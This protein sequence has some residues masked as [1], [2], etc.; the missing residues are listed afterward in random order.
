MFDVTNNRVDRWS[1]WVMFDGRCG[2]QPFHVDR[3][4]RQWANGQTAINGNC[5][6]RNGRERTNVRVLRLSGFAWCGRGWRCVRGRRY[7]DSHEWPL[8]GILFL[9]VMGWRW[10]GEQT[11]PWEGM[12]DGGCWR[13]WWLGG[14]DGVFPYWIDR[15]SYVRP[16]N[17]K[18]LAFALG[19]WVVGR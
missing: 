13:E 17:L 15:E 6:G 14:S 10:S 7:S 9:V 16:L 11:W 1:E 4:S 2:R 12:V 5:S 19:A 18:I 8:G 3:I